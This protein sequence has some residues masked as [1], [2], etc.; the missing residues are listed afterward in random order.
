MDGWM[1]SL[2]GWWGCGFV[3]LDDGAGRIFFFFFVT[4]RLWIY[5]YE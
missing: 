3:R 1:Q 4:N 5:T 2:W